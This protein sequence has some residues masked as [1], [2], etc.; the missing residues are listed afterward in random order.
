MDYC[1]TRGYEEV[2]EDEVP[3]NEEVVP[4][5]NLKSPYQTR[6]MAKTASA[7]MISLGNRSL[8]EILKNLKEIK[9]LVRRVLYRLDQEKGKLILFR[10]K[11]LIL[12]PTYLKRN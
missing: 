2:N 4:K 10:K 7:D 9:K 5:V 3:V 8:K 12:I 6:K 11:M 1:A